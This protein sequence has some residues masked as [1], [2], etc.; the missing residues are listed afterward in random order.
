MARSNAVM[1]RTAT[2]A[3]R[4]SMIVW[5]SVDKAHHAKLDIAKLSD[6]M[7]NQIVV[8]GAA[9]KVGDA[10]AMSSATVAEK[11][12]AMRS[13]IDNLY[14]DKWN[15]A[16]ESHSTL[17]DAILEVRPTA[18]RDTIAE[19]VRKWTEAERSAV[20]RD[21]AIKKILDRMDSETAKASGVK[22]A[23]LLAKI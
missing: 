10:A 6:A 17:I 23:D 15:G 13:V 19:T 2:G 3:G 18:K 12:A 20:R 14:A 11:F 7:F 5:E 1:T 4:N 9:A 22:A 21:P 16:R 8:H